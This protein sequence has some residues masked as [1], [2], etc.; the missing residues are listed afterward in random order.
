MVKKVRG[1]KGIKIA[2]IVKR[3]KDRG[4][5]KY[6]IAKVYDLRKTVHGFSIFLKSMRIILLLKYLSRFLRDIIPLG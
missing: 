3:W 1:L 2:Q 6:R 5:K 4:E